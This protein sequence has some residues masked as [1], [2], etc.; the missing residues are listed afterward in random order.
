MKTPIA[1]VGFG[2]WGEKLAR[3]LKESRDFELCAIVDPSPSA[4]EKA[5]VESFSHFEDVIKNFP[6][7]QAVAIAIPMT[8]QAKLVE[9]ALEQGLHVL[10]TK[11]LATS[12]K[13]AQELIQIAQKKNKALFVDYTFLHA[14][15]FQALKN[16]LSINPEAYSPS[17]IEMRRR[18]LGK[19]DPALAVHWDLACHDLSLIFS[20]FPKEV[21]KSVQA[22]ELT[23]HYGIPSQTEIIL[24]IS[25]FK[26]RINSAWDSPQKIREVEIL[27]AQ[28]NILYSGCYP[29]EELHYCHKGHQMGRENEIQYSPIAWEEIAFTPLE[30]LPEMIREFSQMI[31]TPSNCPSEMYFKII[32]LLEMADQSLKQGG[33]KLSL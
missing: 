12:S 24:E 3:C 31:S 15:G 22:I 7:L 18:A 28:E 5:F 19:F 20:L 17:F 10:V 11:T 30:P 14:Q 6:R 33:Q 21:V 16:L 25:D 27:G 8:E 32:Q 1:L 13:K 4:R 23:R 2:Y 29:N 9:Q 26:I